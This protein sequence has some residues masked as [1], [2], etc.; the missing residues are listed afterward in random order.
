MRIDVIEHAANEGPGKIALWAEARGYTLNHVRVDAGPP[1][2]S[3][4]DSALIVIMGG[5]HEHLRTPGLP[6]ARR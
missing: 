3:L 4:D 5:G 1:L 6:V 2:P